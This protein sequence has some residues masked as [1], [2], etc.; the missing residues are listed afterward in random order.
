MLI[1][2]LVVNSKTMPGAYTG[3]FF[4]T[5]FLGVLNEFLVG[6]RMKLFQAY[7]P[8]GSKYSCHEP[9]ESNPGK[10]SCCEKAERKHPGAIDK[11]ADMTAPYGR[12]IVSFIYFLNIIV[13]YLL[14]LLAMTFDVGIFFATCMGI[15]LGHFVFFR[16]PTKEMMAMMTAGGLSDGCNCG[17]SNA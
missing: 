15:A 10:K 9:D 1:S 8:C 6:I 12:G 5:M 17:T 11:F 3:A 4:F 2:G 14:M 13:G 7:F 16:K